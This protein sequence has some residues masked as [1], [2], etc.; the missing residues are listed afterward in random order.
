MQSIKLRSQ[1]GK[2]GILY[3]EIPVGIADKEL[4][5]M[6]IYQPL[7]PATP[8][9]TPES[10]GWPPAFLSRRLVVYKICLW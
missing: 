8:T 5:V 1:V 9:K 6:V 10:L 4:E 2:D 3:L 7:E